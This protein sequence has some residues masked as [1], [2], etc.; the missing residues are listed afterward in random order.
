M[1]LGSGKKTQQQKN[2]THQK[3]TKTNV[4][5]LKKFPNG[6]LTGQNVNNWGIRVKRSIVL[7]L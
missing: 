2:H 1:D 5:R 6:R 4:G 3:T 7:L